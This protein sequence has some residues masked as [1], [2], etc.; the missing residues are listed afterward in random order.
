MINN[1]FDFLIKY[2]RKMFRVNE[3]GCVGLNIE[4][5]SAIVVSSG[6][7]LLQEVDTGPDK[8]LTISILFGT[9]RRQN[10]CSVEICV[11][12]DTYEVL[13]KETVSASQ[14]AD[15]AYYSL[16]LPDDFS[17]K[18]R[19]YISVASP[20][21]TRANCVAVW[22]AWDPGS[23]L[24]SL[25]SN[26]A[27]TKLSTTEIV[28]GR[29][30]A[31]VA[32]NTTFGRLRSK[33]RCYYREA[34]S[35]E[36]I[37]G[38]LRVVLLL[39]FDENAANE[40]KL[41]N[42]K[43]NLDLHFANVEELGGDNKWQVVLI[44]LSYDNERARVIARASRKKNIPIF[45]VAL[46]ESDLTQKALDN[47]VSYADGIISC[48]TVEATRL[49]QAPIGDELYIPIHDLLVKYQCR[50]LPEVSIVTIL[51]GKADQLKWVIESYFNQSYSGGI[52]VIY[53]DD[54]FGDSESVVAEEFLKNRDRTQRANISYKILRNERNIGNCQSRNRG[55]QAASGD[56]VIIIDADCMLN[57]D[58]ISSHVS[59]QSFLDCEVVIGPHNI[60]TNGA[61]PRTKMQDLESNPAQPLIESELQDRIFLDGF[62]NCITR[63]FSIKKSAV[64]E[65]LFDSDFSYSLSPESGFGWEDVEMGYRLYKRGLG[66]K[67]TEDAF[68][69]HISHPSSVPESEKPRKSIKNFRKLFIKHPELRDVARRW[70]SS[71][72]DE[73]AKWSAKCDGAHE[74]N[75]D[76]AELK[77]LFEGA[78]RPDIVGLNNRVKKLRILTYRWHVPHQY[79]L[80]KSGHDFFLVK[81]TGSPMSDSWEYGQRPFPS[82]AQFINIDDV[83][84]SDFDLA[85]LHFDENVLNYENTNGTVGADWGAAFRHFVEHVNLPKVAVCH[86]TP[87]FYGQYTPGYEKSDL[88]TVIEPARSALVEYVKDIEI[89]CNSHQARMEWGFHKS[90]VIWH[91]FDP[92]EFLPATYSKGILSPLGPLVS[93]RPYYRGFY[94][95]Q[96][97]FSES[98]PHEFRPETLCVPN[99]D[100]EY[101]DN[102]FAVAKYKNYIDQIRK[103]SVYFNPTLRSPMP[104]ARCEP[105]MCG[106]VTVSAHNHDVDLFIRNGVNGFYSND[107][108]ELRGQLIY[109]MKNPG[110]NRKMGAEARKTAI[111]LFN[112][113]RYLADW[114]VLFGESV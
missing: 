107:P 5:G 33:S 91:G 30:H 42:Y 19:F 17:Y 37:I 89:V 109:L 28:S 62:L 88:M 50:R 12:S 92:V 103:Y 25:P 21:A 43:Q 4:P 14:L 59:A 104:R 114:S 81:G 3:A 29:R 72:L 93:S 75:I 67:F 96:E 41:M 70:A 53:V 86:G 40:I 112:H 80:Y 34:I 98:F 22:C 102:V 76:L 38:D 68:S 105:M 113:D 97:V 56:I 74:E 6:L 48:K 24:V 87:Q 39:G 57:K 15:N 63:N 64:T 55:V 73:L 1:I 31:G 47:A 2:A 52:E 20:D 82:N 90:R 54:C 60:E 69:V 32:L 101:I 78:P 94:L 66:I 83:R 35:T 18:G 106:V 85:I 16:L 13:H 58:F 110:V 100:V 26:I 7:T 46:D 10:T 45:T 79:E 65:D 9:F 111:N 23:S 8:I 61:H 84:E 51:S 95:Y 99:P 71:T 108:N 11:Y 27:K 44:P 77:K 49:L 36:N